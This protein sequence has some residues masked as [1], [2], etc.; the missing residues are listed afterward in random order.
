[1]YSTIAKVYD[2]IFPQNPMQLS[3]IDKLS[4]IMKNHT[5]IEIGCATGNLTELLSRKSSHVIG[6]DLDD[7]L[8]KVGNDKYPTLRLEKMNMLDINSLGQHFDKVLCFGNTLVHL[9]NRSLVQEFF[10]KVCESL[11]IEG[12]FIVQII[13]YDRIINKNVDHLATISNEHIEFVRK[14]DLNNT[15]VHFNTELTIKESGQVINNSIPLLTLRKD[16]I[17]EMLTRAGFK[18][19][20]FYGNLKAEPL[21]DAS[22]PLLFSC[23]KKNEK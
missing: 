13:N 18:D 12:A 19:I 21:T 7:E 20:V 2:Y 3:F 17:E 16:E 15:V 8:L 11:S 14:Y 9:P 1:M 22:V 5:I 6:I 23:R 10:H 4:P